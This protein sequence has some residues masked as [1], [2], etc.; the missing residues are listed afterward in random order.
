[1]A[2][3][4]AA[5]MVSNRS[6]MSVAVGCEGLRNVVKGLRRAVE[7]GVRRRGAHAT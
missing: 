1:M 5:C 2:H 6:P 4:V 7:D 3:C